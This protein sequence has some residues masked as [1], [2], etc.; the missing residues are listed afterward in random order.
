MV[1]YSFFTADNIKVVTL[2]LLALFFL[3][4]NIIMFLVLRQ[5]MTLDFWYFS[6]HKKLGLFKMIA[7]KTL[8]LI[9]QV[10]CFFN[11]PLRHSDPILA[12]W[13]YILVVLIL[14]WKF[15]KMRRLDGETKPE[16]KPP[17]F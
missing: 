9:F 7:L 5:N 14:L 6:W 17:S 11:P 15:A 2:V 13:F 8:F 10:Y 16:G 1:M 3:A 12:V 4:D